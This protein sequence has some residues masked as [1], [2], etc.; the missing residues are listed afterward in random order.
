MLYLSGRFASNLSCKNVVFIA[1]CDMKPYKNDSFWSTAIYNNYRTLGK[2][3][4]VTV[5]L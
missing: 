3:K 2:E 4:I 1:L 5:L